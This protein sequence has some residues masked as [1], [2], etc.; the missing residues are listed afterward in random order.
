ML[1][2][3]LDFGMSVQAAIE[4]PRVRAFERTLVDA[5]ARIPAE[6][7]DGLRALGHEINVLP[8]WSRQVGGGHGV[9]IDPRERPD[10]R[11]RRPAPRRR[12][13]R[14]VRPG[15]QESRHPNPPKAVVLTFRPAIPRLAATNRSGPP[16][17]EPSDQ[18]G[19]DEWSTRRLPWCWEAG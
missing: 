19:G 5:E 3:V 10:D 9:A 8:D 14:L 1:L 4:A 2:N 18:P 16:L 7:L 15:R 11:R 13:D 12:G 6:T 17:D